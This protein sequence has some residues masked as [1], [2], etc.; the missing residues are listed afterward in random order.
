VVSCFSSCT[1]GF[2]CGSGVCDGGGGGGG[3]SWYDDVDLR[4]VWV[5]E[6]SLLER[7]ES[8]SSSVFF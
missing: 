2:F 5:F 6:N 8:M 4:G 3:V 1:V 7:K